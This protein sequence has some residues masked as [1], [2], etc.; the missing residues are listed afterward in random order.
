MRLTLISSVLLV[1]AHTAPSL[2]AQCALWDIDAYS[3]PETNAQLG[4]RV[5]IGNA[6]AAVS[7]VNDDTDAG[8]DSG[9]VRMLR[10]A[11]GHWTEAQTV[12]PDPDGAGDLFGTGLALR[13]SWLAVGATRDDDLAP[14]AGAVYLF[15]L[16]NEVWTFKQK[17]FASD[18]ANADHFGAAIAIDGTQLVVGAPEED[19]LGADAGAAYLF[20]FDGTAWSESAK[21]LATSFGGPAD[22]FG[23]AVDIEAGTV[24]VGAPGANL[25][26]PGS[27]AAYALVQVFSSW[28]VQAEL[29]DPQ[30]SANS[31]VGF[32]VQLDGEGAIIGAPG[33]KGYGTC[34][35]FRRSG[36]LWTYQVTMEASDHA[37]GYSFGA[38]LALSQDWLVVGSPFHQAGSGAAYLFEKADTSPGWTE[39]QQYLP[40]DLTAGDHAGVSVGMH[41][42]RAIVGNPLHDLGADKSGSAYVVERHGAW[43]EVERATANGG[44]SGWAGGTQR[45][46]VRAGA[47]Y[48]GS[49]Y[50]VG[51]TMS[52]TVPGVTIGS[53]HVPLNLDSYALYTLN[54]PN[55]PLLPNSF[56][57]LNAAGAADCSFVLPPG[58]VSEGMLLHHA[59]VVLHPSTLGLVYASAAEPLVLH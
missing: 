18:A 53:V 5:A 49:I 45:I 39:S 57:F 8:A 54:N 59:Y 36:T 12:L 22:G 11:L 37:P 7:S 4:Q 19:T 13:G 23:S 58:I 31:L 48:A 26:G 21:L 34:L 2:S 52:G 6:W 9:S 3:D 14:D 35:V 47:G 25:V 16:E 51:G 40:C 1:A 20:T 42:D 41:G 33:A 56:G 24:L 38:A 44:F 15:F 28:I 50:F 10:N 32:A 43:V 30:P 29:A 46:L 27:G 17:L 55:S